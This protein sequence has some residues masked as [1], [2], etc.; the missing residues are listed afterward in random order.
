MVITESPVKTAEPIKI[1]LVGQTRGDLK[2]TMYWL[3]V[4]NWAVQ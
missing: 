1:P 2:L 4:Y 3:G